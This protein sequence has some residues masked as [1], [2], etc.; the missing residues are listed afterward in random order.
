MSPHPTFHTQ[1]YGEPGRGPSWRDA[2]GKNF[3]TRPKTEVHGPVMARPFRPPLPVM[4]IRSD[5]GRPSGK[6]ALCPEFLRRN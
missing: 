2:V 5:E 1:G 6:R 4:V 3:S